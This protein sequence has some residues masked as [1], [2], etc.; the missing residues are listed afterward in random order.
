[1]GSPTSIHVVGLHPVVPTPEELRIARDIQWGD[2]LVDEALESANRAVREHFA[3]LHLIEI[4]VEPSESQVDWIA[5]TQP[6]AG[7]PS[8]VWQVPWDE[9]STGE[10]RWAFFLHFVQ[11]NQPLQTSIGPVQLPAPTPIPPHLA[12]VEYHLPG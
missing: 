8:S 7:K 5:I 1:M 3:G 12:S 4:E 9:R 2:E 11:V 6:I 10:G